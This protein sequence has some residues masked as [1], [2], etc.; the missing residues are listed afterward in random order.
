VNPET[1]GW[2]RLTQLL[3]LGRVGLGL[4]ALTAPNLP[5]RPWVGDRSH[6]RGALLLA[7]ALGGRDI[8]L[9]LGA[10]QAMLRREPVRGWVQAGVVADSVDAAYTALAFR[11]LPRAGRW[12]VLAAAGSAVLA[13]LAAGRLDLSPTVLPS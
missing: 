8:A 13:G 1:T 6:D 7:R 2:R 5:L 4:A 9:G 3:A 12:A 10:L 11:H